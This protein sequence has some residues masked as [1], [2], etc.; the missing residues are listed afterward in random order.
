MKHEKRSLAESIALLPESERQKILSD[1][2]DDEVQQLEYDWKFWARPNQLAPEGDWQYWLLLAGRGYGKTKTGAEWIRER[3]ESDKAHRIALVA[4]TAADARDTMV[5]G[6]SG[7]LSVCPPW[8]RPVYEPSKR[9]LTWPNGAIAL[10]FSAEEPDRLRGPQHDTAWCD[11]I[12]A[13]KYPDRTWDMLQFGLRLGDDPRAAITTTPRPIPLV[14]N[15]LNDAST[16]VTRGSTYENLSNLAPAFIDVIISRYEGTRLGR[17]ELN[18]EILDDN[19]DALWTRQMIEDAR[20]SKVPNLLRIVVGVDP[21]VTSNETSADTGIVVAAVDERGEYYVLGDYT[22]HATPKKWAQE[23]IAAYYK[24]SADRVVG[25]VNNGGELVEYTLRT[26][27]P[28]VSYRSVRA[29]RGKQT[30][31]EPI[32]AL[33]EQG[34]VHHVGSFPALEDQ[35]CDW[36]PG[37][38]S[39]PDRVDA[40]VW[41]LSELSRSR[42]GPQ[43]LNMSA[44]IKT[45]PR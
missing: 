17:Q 44:L 7:I 8:N 31:A 13:W 14:K 12:A 33:Y 6:E 28:N 23:I 38:G 3:V 27:D 43:K 45:R 9:R 2:S 11:E 39:S 15:I 10:L 4:P 29:S 19:P 20:E 16:H 30:R 42:Y 1:L 32:S 37:E 34:K 22:I 35:M 41:A 24:H 36:I 18:A 5:E 26:I 40:L 21:A 25:E